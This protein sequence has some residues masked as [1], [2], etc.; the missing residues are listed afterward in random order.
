MA[1]STI[2]KPT[3]VITVSALLPALP[4]GTMTNIS[5][6]WAYAKPGMVQI[7]DTH[8]GRAIAVGNYWVENGYLKLQLHNVCQYD[9]GEEDV[10]IKGLL[11]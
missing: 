10:Q 5:V 3:Q 9:R 2:P 8:G 11:C 6:P 7:I 4:K 1:I